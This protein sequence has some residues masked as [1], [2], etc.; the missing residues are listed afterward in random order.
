MRPN[1]P[2]ALADQ[3]RL[4]IERQIGAF[5]AGTLVCSLVLQRFALPIGENGV[6]VVFPVGILLAIIALL[7]GA[8][9]FHLNRVRVF[10]LFAG[11][12]FIGACAQYA[13]PNSYGVSYSLNSVSQFLILTGFC[14]L[15]FSIQVDEAIFV[16]YAT[17][18]LLLVAIAGILQFV[19]QFAGVSLFTFSG[20]IPARLLFESNYNV[21]IPAGVQSLIKSNGFFLLEPSIFSQTMAMALILEILTTKRMIHLCTFIGALLVSF[22]GTGLL[23]FGSFLLSVSFIQRGRGLKVLLASVLVLGIIALLLSQFVP[24]FANVF[25]NRLQE[26]SQVGTSGYLRFITP[27]KLLHSVFNANEWAWLI[28]IGA[29][30]AERIDLPFFFGANTPVKILVEYGIPGLLLYLTLIFTAERTRLQKAIMLPC[31]VLLLFTGG[32]QEFAPVLFPVFLL[33]CVARLKEENAV[34]SITYKRP[35]NAWEVSGGRAAIVS[36]YV[37]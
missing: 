18:I 20:V 19:V 15:S 3:R 23:I 6:D 8:L 2:I 12:L 7:Q 9:K 16:R 28:G 21:V 35:G 11:W 36:P 37:V 29:G 25:V 27:F 1:D 33:I 5:A 17:R 4:Q 22:S 13:E 24:E 34:D 10:L 31:T 26:I 30:V 32:Y 14:T